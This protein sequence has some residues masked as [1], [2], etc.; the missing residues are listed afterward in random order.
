MKKEYLKNR[1]KIIWEYPYDPGKKIEILFTILYN[2]KLYC[3]FRFLDEEEGTTYCTCFTFEEKKLQLEE[4]DRQKGQ[5]IL[6]IMECILEDGN[7]QPGQHFVWLQDGREL[8]LQDGILDNQEKKGWERLLEWY[9]NK[10]GLRKIIKTL[11]AS[12]ILVLVFIWAV[13]SVW[14]NVIEWE[15]LLQY[16]HFCVNGIRISAT[17]VRMLML[18]GYFVICVLLYIILRK[19]SVKWRL[20][21]V[22]IGIAIL[23]LTYDALLLEHIESWEIEYVERM[24][25]NYSLAKRRTQPYQDVYFEIQGDQIIIPLRV[26]EPDFPKSMQFNAWFQWDTCLDGSK[27]YTS[28]INE[29]KTAAVITIPELLT[30]YQYGLVTV[31]ASEDPYFGTRFPLG[32]KPQ[33]WYQKLLGTSLD[34]DRINY[35]FTFEDAIKNGEINANSKIIDL[36]RMLLKVDFIWSLS[37][38]YELWWIMLILFMLYYVSSELDRDK[39]SEEIWTLKTVVKGEEE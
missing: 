10:T 17:A 5:E 31:V 33:I 37:Y 36:W 35:D 20:C 19:Y 23:S 14:A 38:L 3:A 21:S 24:D 2:S 9:T 26:E 1:K 28:N 15:S 32:E 34:F 6:S 8:L 16:R 7:Y 4:I 12:L 30:E 18:V 25:Y 22:F 29:E 27:T 11:T 13:A 39:M